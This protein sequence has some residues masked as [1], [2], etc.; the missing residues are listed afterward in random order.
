[1]THRVP[2]PPDQGD[3]IRDYHVLSWLARHA[4]VDLACLADEEVSEADVDA[5]KELADRVAIVRIRR[6]SRR[7]RATWSLATGRTASEG[8]FRSSALCGLL[9]RW[10]GEA[11]YH[12]ILVSAS[13][14]VPYLRLV[15]FAG[16]PAVVDFVD[17]DS[18]KWLDYA[19]ASR[20]PRAWLYRT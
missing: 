16:T 18:Q 4:S 17:V 20:R 14:L 15:E 11:R 19:G 7:I 6:G 3:R 9:R 12:A 2:Y 1:M 10:A 5:L 8:A 13:S